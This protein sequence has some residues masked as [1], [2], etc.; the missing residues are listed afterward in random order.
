MPLGR[1]GGTESGLHTDW[2]EAHTVQSP[3]PNFTQR[4]HWQKF[5]IDLK[6]KEPPKRQH[7][8]LLEKKIK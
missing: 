7:Q 6:K 2:K 8:N 5:P 1:G 4:T 3:D